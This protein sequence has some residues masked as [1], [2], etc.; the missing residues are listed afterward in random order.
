[1]GE[2]S[3]PILTLK[4]DHLIHETAFAP[5]LSSSQIDNKWQQCANSFG[6]QYLINI[7]S[8]WTCNQ[9]EW[10]QWTRGVKLQLHGS[11]MSW[12]SEK[13][14]VELQIQLIILCRFVT[15]SFKLITLSLNCHL[16]R[17]FYTDIE[18]SCYNFH[19]NRRRFFIQCSLFLSD[20]DFVRQQ[21][22]NFIWINSKKKFIATVWTQNC[23]ENQSMDQFNLILFV[24]VVE[25]CTE[26][27]TKSNSD[28]LLVSD[29]FS[30]TLRKERAVK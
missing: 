7:F 12:N 28:R 4:L 14:W 8:C 30:R 9:W 20:S 24:T 21:T 23:P 26:S 19:N 25:V 1:M 11:T 5:S 10:R 16:I 2:G 29:T 27:W 18:Y 17:R 15:M 3:K 6:V 13:S 22:S